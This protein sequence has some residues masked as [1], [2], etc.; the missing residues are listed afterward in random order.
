MFEGDQSDEDDCDSGGLRRSQPLAEQGQTDADRDH[1]L[2][3]E[4]DDARVL[5][6]RD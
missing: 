2:D 6:H 4:T 3:A 1:G 5:I